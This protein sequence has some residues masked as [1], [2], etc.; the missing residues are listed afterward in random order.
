MFDYD[1]TNLDQ[2][3]YRLIRALKYTEMICKALPSFHS[4]LKLTQKNNLIELIYLYPR[5]IIFAI[6][7]PLD[8]DLEQICND[9]LDYAKR[10]QKKKKNGDSYT[11]NDILEIINDSARTIML[12]MFDHFSELA[13]SPKSIDLLISKRTNDISEQLERLLMI[14]NSGNTDRLVKESL[15]LLKTYKNTEYETMIK[16]IVRK[17]LLTNKGLT[18]NK[19]QHIIDKIFGQENRKYFLISNE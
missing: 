10:N 3:Q 18:F 14:E 15:L 6:L 12:S 19:K 9:M 5:K 11:T 13:T 7:R 2:Y 8:M 16:L 4:Q 17:H 1:D